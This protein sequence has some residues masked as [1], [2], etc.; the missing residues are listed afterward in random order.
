[1]LDII[2]KVKVKLQLNE[3]DISQSSMLGLLEPREFAIEEPF[4]I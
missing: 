2:E 3:E 4:Q 1:M